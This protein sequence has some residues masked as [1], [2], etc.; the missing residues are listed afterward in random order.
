MC[1]AAVLGFMGAEEGT[2]P[3]YGEQV[4]QAVRSEQ[5][6]CDD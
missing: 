3:R 6:L 2:V 4:R 1:G 5:G